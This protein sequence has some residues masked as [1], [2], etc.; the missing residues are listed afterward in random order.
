LALPYVYFSHHVTECLLSTI[1]KWKEH[2]WKSE[3]RPGYM[4][5]GP[6]SISCNLWNISAG[7]EILLNTL[8]IWRH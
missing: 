2:T 7:L 8:Y 1:S 4:R 3:F 6:L 5:Y